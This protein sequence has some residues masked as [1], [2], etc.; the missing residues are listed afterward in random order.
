MHLIHGH[1]LKLDKDMKWPTEKQNKYYLS[2]RGTPPAT[3]SPTSG[4]HNLDTSLP[5][6]TP[7][8]TLS[9]LSDS[10][11][12]ENEKPRGLTGDSEQKIPK[13]NGK[14]TDFFKSVSGPRR[15]QTGTDAWSDSLSESNKEKFESSEGSLNS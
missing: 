5:R 6:G 11:I 12:L 13:L 7:P 14:V 9:P 2:S 8:A 10:H 1:D 15:G 3:L 4:S